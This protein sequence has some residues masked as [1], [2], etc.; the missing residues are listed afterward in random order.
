[1]E[2]YIPE[3]MEHLKNSIPSACGYFPM[4]DNDPEI[5]KHMTCGIVE[6]ERKYKYT[7]PECRSNCITIIPSREYVYGDW[8]ETK[9]S[10][11]HNSRKIGDQKWLPL[12]ERSDVPHCKR[13]CCK[14]EVFEFVK[15]RDEDGNIVELRDWRGNRV[16]IIVKKE[17]TT[18]I[19]MRDGYARKKDGK[20]IPVE[21]KEPE[22]LNNRGYA[23]SYRRIREEM[24]KGKKLADRFTGSGEW[25]SPMRGSKGVGFRRIKEDIPKVDELFKPNPITFEEYVN[26]VIRISADDIIEIKGVKP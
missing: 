19:S 6:R 23:E 18:V 8:E 25:T 12:P 4:D 16:P 13:A 17:P 14:Y 20:F 5:D 10:G 9:E 2:D 1:M 21:H 7:Q 26:Q 24:K 15:V 22:I 11:V 3:D